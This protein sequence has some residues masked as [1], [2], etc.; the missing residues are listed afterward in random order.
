MLF[1]V[2]VDD[3]LVHFPNYQRHLASSNGTVGR[4][5]FYPQHSQN[6]PDKVH[7]IE[8]KLSE[9][10]VLFS[11]GEVG[12]G[13]A[14][15]LEFGA[16]SLNAYFSWPFAMFRQQGRTCLAFLVSFPPLTG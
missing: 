15:A 1:P 14:G 6:R 11:G 10:S 12:H 4:S 8:I 9:H 2:I 5:G 3:K 13:P 7:E 16:V